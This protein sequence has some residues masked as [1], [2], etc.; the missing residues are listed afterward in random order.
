MKIESRI[1]IKTNEEETKPK[2]FEKEK[3]EKSRKSR[4]KHGKKFKVELMKNACV[5]SSSCSFVC[6]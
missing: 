1:K 4:R 5:S 2:S 3:E 6:S